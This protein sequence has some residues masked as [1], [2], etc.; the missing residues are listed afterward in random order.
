MSE[1][2]VAGLSKEYDHFIAVDSL[3]I[4]IEKGEVFGIVGPNGAGKDYNPE[5]LSALI[6]PTRGSIKIQGMDIRRMPGKSNRNSVF[7]RRKVHFM[8]E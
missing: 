5:M 3:D 8:K 2:E 4:N 1:I 7:C 6:T